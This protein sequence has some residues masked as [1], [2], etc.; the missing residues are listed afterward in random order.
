MLQSINCAYIITFGITLDLPSS[1]LHVNLY[2]HSFVSWL[3][4]KL[5]YNPVVYLES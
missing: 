1:I 5:I 2:E 4:L 3:Q